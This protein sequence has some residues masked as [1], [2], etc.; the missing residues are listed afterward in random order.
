MSRK[1]VSPNG[2]SILQANVNKSQNVLQSLLN[3]QDLEEYVFLL[4]TE[5]WSH[6]SEEAYPI[7]RYHS[8][9]LP[10]YPSKN[11]KRPRTK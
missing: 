9:R 4:L 1:T 7:P 11:Q 6:I 8:H 2:F 3:D 10:Y 5:Q